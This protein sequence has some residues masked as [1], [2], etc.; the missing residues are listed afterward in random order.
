M[1]ALQFYT[2]KHT[3]LSLPYA[4]RFI[5]RCGCTRERLSD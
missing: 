5:V 2:G 1:P 3:P 4:S